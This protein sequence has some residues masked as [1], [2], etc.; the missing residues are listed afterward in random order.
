MELLRGFGAPLVDMAPGMVALEDCGNL[1]SH[2]PVRRV[3]AEKYLVR[4]YR[5][6]QNSV[7][8]NMLNHVVWPPGS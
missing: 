1:I 3:I 2:L 4:H 8:S 6:L 7:Q 5:P